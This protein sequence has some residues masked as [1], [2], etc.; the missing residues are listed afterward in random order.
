MEQ[1]FNLKFMAKQLGR[2]A[3]KAEK[4]RMD[5]YSTASHE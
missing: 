5:G 3:V 4:V 2:A 1:I